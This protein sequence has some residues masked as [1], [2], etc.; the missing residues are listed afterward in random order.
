MLED[1]IVFE[2]DA[3]ARAERMPPRC[4]LIRDEAHVDE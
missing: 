3:I 4:G 1:E 2:A